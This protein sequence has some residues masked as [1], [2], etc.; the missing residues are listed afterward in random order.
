[1]GFFLFFWDYL[2]ISRVVF[3]QSILSDRIWLEQKIKIFIEKD[4]SDKKVSLNFS[5]NLHEILKNDYKRNDQKLILM[6]K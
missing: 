2:G 1:M 4:L 3:A 6:Q 5:N